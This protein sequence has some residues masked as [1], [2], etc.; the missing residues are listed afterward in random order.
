MVQSYL[1]ENELGA[2]SLAI[3]FCNVTGYS[4]I[5]GIL[6]A[7]D[8]LCSQAFGSKNYLL[9]GVVLQRGLF[10]GYLI[11]VPIGVLW[12]FSEQLLLL[13]RQDPTVA[14]LTGMYTRWLIPCLVPYVAVDAIRRYLIAQSITTPVVVSALC[15]MV[16]K[17][18]VSP[19]N[20]AFYSVIDRPIRQFLN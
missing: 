16:R 11:A 15:G 8:T 17:Q 12:L 14:A 3:V 4:V 9:L 19:E 5:Q 2:A 7:L 10:I 6:T 13:A 20:R 18:V 1:G